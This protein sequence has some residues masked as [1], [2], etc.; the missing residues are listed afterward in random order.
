MSSVSL[1]DDVAPDKSSRVRDRLCI[2]F[3]RQ[4]HRGFEPRR[5]A[6]KLLGNERTTMSNIIEENVFRF[7]VD[8]E[9]QKATRLQYPVSVVCMAPDLGP[10]EVDPSLTKHVAETALRRL[11]ATDVVTTLPQSSIGLLLID[12]ESWALP[13]I[14]QRVKE[15]IEAHPLTVGGRERHVTWSAGG[16]SYPQTAASGRYLLHQ[17]IDLMV[18]ARGQ[19]GGRLFLPA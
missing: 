6:V 10:G 14:H 4:L 8:L 13:R 17:A 7:L 18:R 15:E 9:V 19:G 1:L 16:G 5:L 3:Y 2:L 11:R 12:A